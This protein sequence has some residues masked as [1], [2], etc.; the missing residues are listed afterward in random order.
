MKKFW[1]S[2]A[3]RTESIRS[4]LIVKWSALGDVILSTAIFQDVRDAFPR[5]AIDLN[6]TRP[7]RE[8]F[9][10]DPRFRSVESYDFKKADRTVAGLWRW[11]R[12]VRKGE[13]DLIIDLQS[14]DR[15][16]L[17]LSLVRMLSPGRPAMVGL[18]HRYP[19][20]L[21]PGNDVAAG[22]IRQQRAVAAAGIRAVTSSPRLHVPPRNRARSRELADSH[23][24]RDG[25]FA[26]F[27]PGSNPSG[28]LKRWGAPRYA[29]LADALFLEGLGPAVLIGG[30]DD[31]EE[32]A[33]IGRLAREP[34]SVVN[35]CG[36]TEILDIVPLTEGA[37]FIV[38]N[39]TGPTHVSSASDRPL[40]VIC[41]PTDPRRVKPLGDN[42]V[43]VQAELGCVNC[44]QKEC[45]HHSCME[46]VSVEMI[47]DRV[48]SMLAG[49]DDG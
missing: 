19:Y 18:H 24:L 47:L 46:Q 1:G 39:D 36:K 2:E 40:I 10:E 34:G 23:G 3:E 20:H 16:R 5:A 4:I 13:Y 9:A 27:L 32:C 49:S 41:G 7:Y 29:A 26:V 35:L 48:R 6:T 31:L 11:V 12:H 25:R 37:R 15:S 21:A 33:E 43:A 28:K 14:N 30:P 8:L 42:V 17:L 22:F 38:G 44:Y 45:D